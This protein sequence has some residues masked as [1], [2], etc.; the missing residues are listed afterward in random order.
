[1]MALQGTTLFVFPQQSPFSASE[2]ELQ[3]M[4]EDS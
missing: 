1:M 2:Y 4:I 3:N